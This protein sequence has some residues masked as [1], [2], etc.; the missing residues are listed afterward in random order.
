MSNP[1]YQDPNYSYE[2]R[3]YMTQPARTSTEALDK[4]LATQKKMNKTML[5]LIFC[6]V[7]LV[8]PPIGIAVIL[9]LAWRV[10]KLSA[11]MKDLYKDAF[12]LEPLQN[13]FE[14]VHYEPNGGF[15]KENIE[16]FGLCRMGNSFWSE[17]YIRATYQGVV[18][19]VGEVHVRQVDKSGDS[20]CT[21]T[22]FE[23]RM[24]VFSFPNK[25][26]NSVSI[27]SRKF[28]HRP[29]SKR[30]AKETAVE[31]ENLQFNDIFDVYSELQQDAFYLIT[32]HF[33]DR[34]ITLSGRYDNIA[35]HVVGNR[36]F[37]G[38]N[39]PGKRFF[40]SSVDAG[41]FDVNAEM[42]K[43][44]SEI[45]DIKTLITAILNLRNFA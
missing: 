14:N 7:L 42:Q 5:T 17:D 11:Q 21:E 31:L 36:V 4:L 13:N 35:M 20:R 45:D 39:E 2:S 25:L 22:Y 41:Q 15:L 28:K 43:V 18:F 19:E 40:D 33:M 26:V 44:Q 27:F 32:P 16:A 34:L 24:M 10:R 30:E 12:V 29:L 9:F 1:N 23:G 37:V 38:F 6:V 8:I 3:N